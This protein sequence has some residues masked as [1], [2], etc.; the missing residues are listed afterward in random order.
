MS[1]VTVA[2]LKERYWEIDAFRGISLVGM[3]V[4][5]TIF[6]LGVFNILDVSVWEWICNYIEFGTAV[7]VVIC[8]VALVLRHARMADKPRKEYYLA[9][10]KR[11][12]EIFLIGVAV[13]LVCSAAVYLFIKDG[14]YVYFNFLQMMGICMLLSIPFLKFGKLNFIFAVVLFVLGLFLE[15]LS[16]PA[17][18]MPLGILPDGFVPRDYFPFVK[19][20]GVML[21]GVALGSVF[22][23]KGFRRFELPKA[24]RAGRLFALI[25]KYPLQIY[26][27]HLPVIGGAVILIVLVSG[28]LGFPI[29]SI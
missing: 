8:G 22:Y 17:F 23:P 10:V 1:E 12:V 14:R 18:L 16:G 13:A 26:L 9:I 29:G 19:W 24:N 11:G 21:L 15:S 25:G 4:F 7:F 3:I 27:I 20:L 28:A 5:H 2:P 6:V